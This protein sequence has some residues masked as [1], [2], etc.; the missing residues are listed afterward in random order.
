MR[1]SRSVLRGGRWR[2]PIAAL[3]AAIL[4]IPLA[5]A[6]E[7]Q[8]VSADVVIAEV[9]GGGGN[10]GAPYVNDF[11]ELHNRGGSSVSLAGWSVQY[12]SASGASWLVTSLS[13]S[14]AA[15]ASYLV[16]M[17]SGGSTGAALP[18]PDATGTTNMSATAGKVAVRTTATAL[19]CSTGCSTASGVRDFLGYGGASSYE[20]SPSAAGS[21]TTS[22]A[23]TNPEADTD[24]NSTDFAAGAP[25]PQN[26]AGGG[27]GGDCGGYTG[28]RIRAIQ[29]AAHVSPKNGQAVTN[30]R[31]VVTALKSNGFFLQDPCPDADV[32]TSEGVFVFTSAAPSVAAGD[33]VAV[34]G[35]VSEF[36]SGTSALS[37]TELTGPS[38]THLGTRALPAPIVVGTGGRVPPSAVIDDDANGSVETGGTFDATTDGIDFYESLEGMR[39]QLNNPVAVGP[40]AASYG[41]IPI[42]GDNGANAGVRT[43]RGGI[44]T[45]ETDHNPERITLDDAV[46][47]HSTPAGVN[48]GDHFSGPAVGPVDYVAGMFM[49]ELTSPLTRVA[50][51]ITKETTPVV[52]AGRLSVATFNV[53]N[54]APGDPQSKFDGLANVV[55]NNLRAPD[56][57]A[58]EEIQDNNGATDD[59]T[60]SATQTWAKFIAAISSA[61]GPP[62][63]YKEIDPVNDADGGEPGGNIRQGFLFRTDVGELSFAPGTAGTST[64][65]V[66]VT[67]TGDSSD[68]VGLTVN[69][70][71]LSPTDP[72]FNA[73]RKPLIGKFLFGGKPVFVIANHFNSKGG[74]DYEWG[75]YQPPNQVSVAQRTG[76]ATIV[77]GLVSQITAIDP[78]AR[79]VVA[80]DLND[81]EF[82][83]AL[84]TLDA[85]GL[86]DLPAT[87]PDAERYT[88]DFEGNSQVLDHILL[89]ASLNG[90]AHGYDVVHVNSEFADQ[91]SDHDPQV[92]GLT[93]P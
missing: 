9:Y 62:Y 65:A 90:A 45:R 15:G 83:T 80:G 28:T 41:E 7:A 88:Y 60:V 5:A 51:P 64:Q 85:A 25:D 34:N 20:G 19:T 56:I 8:A 42:V 47:A 46:L 63:T 81:Y 66:G 69:P 4:T 70:G 1:V 6:P 27:G 30:V 82:S 14:I 40:Y 52:P 50:G 78:N 37:V 35:T 31:G 13:G 21:N 91:V 38:V 29:G 67:S 3:S 43:T 17:A 10:G 33:E 59:G 86:S 53:E 61:G 12:A 18:A 58:I 22:L 36:R 73:S 87:L 92:V 23:R 44:V 77:A 89:S 55:V 74:D 26:S 84:Q 72:A 2:V 24:H 68:P 16:K 49:L 57:L 76:Q 54:L 75:R 93:V 32:A 71:R 11:V 48:V 39:V 79:I